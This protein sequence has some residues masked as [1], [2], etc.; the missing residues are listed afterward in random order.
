MNYL[1]RS[2]SLSPTGI[3]RPFRSRS[4]DLIR[5]HSWISVDQPSYMLGNSTSNNDDLLSKH[6]IVQKVVSKVLDGKNDKKL[7]NFAHLQEPSSRSEVLISNRSEK[8]PI[9]SHSTTTTKN[10]RLPPTV[11]VVISQ[12]LKPSLI[13]ITSTRRYLK[14]STTNKAIKFTQRS[15]ISQTIP[16]IGRK[17]NSMLNLNF[18]LHIKSLQRINDKNSSNE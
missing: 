8:K 6:L 17:T 7:N 1:I 9:I 16:N 4:N 13:P 18:D 14:K 5:W 2:S 3:K 11:N 10:I 12:T 15:F